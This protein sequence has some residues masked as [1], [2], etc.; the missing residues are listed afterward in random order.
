[1]QI[2]ASMST[3]LIYIY[4]QTVPLHTICFFNVAFIEAFAIWALVYTSQTNSSW[5]DLSFIWSLTIWS[6]F[7]MKSWT[8]CNMFASRLYNRDRPGLVDCQTIK[9]MWTWISF[10]SVTL[11]VLNLWFHV[12]NFGITREIE[13]QVCLNHD[14]FR[15][16]VLSNW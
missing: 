1:M 11:L 6:V 2:L 4:D 14:D 10:Q 5:T 16:R 7:C 15:N 8:L 9:I 3:F 13:S 12:G